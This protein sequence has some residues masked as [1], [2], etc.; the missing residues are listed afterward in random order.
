MED[1]KVGGRKRMHARIVNA[2]SNKEIQTLKNIYVS[3]KLG[4]LIEKKNSLVVGP[5]NLHVWM[6][7]SKYIE[8]YYNSRC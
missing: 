1:H 4:K 6:R 7:P 5:N 2:A 3:W 8:R